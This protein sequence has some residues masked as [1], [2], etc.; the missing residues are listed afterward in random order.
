MKYTNM[1][2]HTRK[3]LQI[4]LSQ[5]KI[6]SFYSKLGQ[7]QSQDVPKNVNFLEGINYFIITKMTTLK[8]HFLSYI[9]WKNSIW[10]NISLVQSKMT[11]WRHLILCRD[12]YRC[13]VIFSILWN[14]RSQ[15]HPFLKTLYF[16]AQN[17]IKNVLTHCKMK[18]SFPVTKIFAIIF[19]YDHTYLCISTFTF[20]S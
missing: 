14:P 5:E 10:D 17:V 11:C 9:G 13:F 6:F 20:Y 18:I 16:W 1:C 12:I 4:Y 2:D 15:N 8:W 7:F 3:L 19:L